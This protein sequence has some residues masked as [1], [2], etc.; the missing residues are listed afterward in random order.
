MKKFIKNN[1]RLSEFKAFFLACRR[2]VRYAVEHIAFLMRS[3]QEYGF[4]VSG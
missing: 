1:M 2:L 4:P 3:P